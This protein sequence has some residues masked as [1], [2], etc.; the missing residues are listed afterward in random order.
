MFRA[1]V[2]AGFTDLN[3]L[4]EELGPGIIEL[5]YSKE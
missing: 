2:M 1:G 5:T 3:Y 4:K